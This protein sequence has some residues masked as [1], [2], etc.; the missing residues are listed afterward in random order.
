M[1][2][3]YSHTSLSVEKSLTVTRNIFGSE[4]GDA[5]SVLRVSDGSGDM[6]WTC[7]C[8]GDS[9]KNSENDKIT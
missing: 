7:Q 2:T 8:S 9:L 1:T 3:L 5:S 4:S 6:M